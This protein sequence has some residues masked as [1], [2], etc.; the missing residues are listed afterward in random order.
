M[1]GIAG[2]IAIKN[3]LINESVVL[4]MT[5][6]IKHRGPD[7][8]GEYINTDC[9][10]VFGH[11]RLSILDLSEFGSQPMEFNESVITY[12][13]EIYNY[14]ELRDE[15]V[16]LGNSFYTN[17]DTEVILAAY[18]EWGY[19]CI[20]RFNGMWAF[21]IYDKSKDIV[22]CS[23]DRYGIKPFYYTY[24]NGDFYFA[25]EIKCFT[26]LQDWISTL[27]H[28]KAY[29]FLNSGYLSHSEETLFK[30]V[31]ELRGG[32]NYIIN[33][34]TKESN[35]YM[36]YDTSVFQSDSFFANEEQTVTKFKQLLTDAIKI[37]LRSDV[38]VGSALSGGLDSSTI[39]AV[40]NKLLKDEKK[41]GLQECISAC[42]ENNEV[43]VDESKYIDSLAAHTSLSV[44]KVF[45]SWDKFLDSIDKMV[46]F[47][48]EPIPTMSIFAQY[49]VFEEAKK[50][51]IKVMLDGQGADEILAGY[52]S[53]YKPYFQTIIKKKPLHAIQSFLNY[54]IKHRQYPFRIIKKILNINKTK[55]AFKKTFLDGIQPFVRP[56]DSNIN[57]ASNNHIK[58]F[59]LH[60][61]LRFEDRN[62][63]AFSIESRVP[64]LDY[65]IV[66]MSLLLNDEFKINKGVRKYILR[67][68][69][70]DIL[71]KSIYARFDKLGF[72]TPQERWT[73]ENADYVNNL[74]I[75]SVKQFPQIFLEE[76]L[77][78]SH[79]K[80]M[81]KD[82]EFIFFVWRVINFKKWVD[83]FSVN[84]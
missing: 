66:N 22:F 46:W 64:F 72:P 1:C 15:L 69:F 82:K 11:R 62:S 48:D 57:I 12:N 39:V 8:C 17:T 36:Y 51:N 24:F 75:E 41:E 5:D 37:S 26:I 77:V 29:D 30:D 79:K 70:K 4:K 78:G 6:V 68:A 83:R 31:F 43:N 61:L 54:I 40:I 60:S 3:S 28:S 19:S 53:F 27:N 13:G 38:N 50:N 20:E 56:I 14:I 63:M 45:P 34:K 55:I 84:L 25:S 16:K 80:I 42:Y 71:P 21:A 47:Q 67:E 76:I 74:F 73:L 81:K 23:R 9:T 18:K 2:V 35:K 49:C 7:S 52:E 33:V 59:A 10:V 44:H 58:G 65:R 32:Y